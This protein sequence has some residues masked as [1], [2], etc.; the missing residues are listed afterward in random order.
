M[1]WGKRAGERSTVDGCS[2]LC[3]LQFL[4]HYAVRSL[5]TWMRSSSLGTELLSDFGCWA[6]VCRGVRHG[7]GGWGEGPGSS[8]LPVVAESHFPALIYI[9]TSAAG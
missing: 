8:A 9:W 6:S 2:Q 1:G 7:C 4:R 3:S 5:Q